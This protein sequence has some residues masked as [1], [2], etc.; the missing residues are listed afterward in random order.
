ML[1]LPTDS[2]FRKAAGKINLEHGLICGFALRADGSSRRV[3]LDDVR[4]AV[5][6]DGTVVWLHF[7]AS[8][9]SARHWL[10]QSKCASLEFLRLVGEH[11][12][13]VRL[14]ATESAVVGVITNLA[15]AARVDPSEVVTV[16]V[17]ASQRLIVTA[18]NHAAQTADLMRQTARQNLPA[19]SGQALL[20][21]LLEVQAD[22]LREWLAGAAHELDHVEDQ[23]LIGHVSEQRENLGRIRRLAMHLR[24]NFTPQRMALHRLLSQP[25]ERRGGIDVDGWRTVHDDFAFAMDEATNVYERAKLLQEELSSRLAETTSRNLYVLTICTLVFLPMTLITGIFGMNV[26]GVPGVGEIPSPHA[27]WWVML[28]MLFAGFVALLLLRLRRLF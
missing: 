14:S 8:N 9:A 6:E 23:I 2:A 25:A 18:R 22:A 3:E 17:Y 1:S 12:T 10:S 5:A 24:R 7:N 26:A 19:A 15:F 4:A 28:L 13:R 20:S 27:F 16:W 11:E 21:H